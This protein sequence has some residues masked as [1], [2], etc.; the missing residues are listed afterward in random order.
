[1]HL[2]SSTFAAA[3]CH[4]PPEWPTPS[5]HQGNHFTI[6]EGL[7]EFHFHLE[8]RDTWAPGGGQCTD[9]N[10]AMWM[11]GAE[12][13]VF[14][15]AWQVLIRAA[16]ITVVFLLFS[17]KSNKAGSGCYDLQQYIRYDSTIF[18]LEMGSKCQNRQARFLQFSHPTQRALLTSTLPKPVWGYSMGDS[19]VISPNI[20]SSFLFAWGN[21]RR[22]LKGARLTSFSLVSWL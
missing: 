13:L 8:E 3:D 10:A 19:G 17:L 14:L 16:I 6:S 9:I 4:I 2:V 12:N 15:T 1:M 7:K 11:L 20:A 22:K 18:L 5:N 21:R